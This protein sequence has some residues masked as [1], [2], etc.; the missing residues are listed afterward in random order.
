MSIEEMGLKEMACEQIDN[1]VKEF[2]IKNKGSKLTKDQLFNNLIDAVNNL[3]TSK[4]F[5]IVK[6]SFFLKSTITSLRKKNEK[7]P[8]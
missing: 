8:L 3:D 2:I 5:N 7:L 1:L 6:E 4:L